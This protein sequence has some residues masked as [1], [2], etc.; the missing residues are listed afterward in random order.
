[1]CILLLGV[2]IAILSD[3]LDEINCEY[4]GSLWHHQD[5]FIS[6]LSKKQ[7][8]NVSHHKFVY[9]ALIGHLLLESEASEYL[10]YL[11]S[12]TMYIELIANDIFCLYQ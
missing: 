10:K 1:M 4:N 12:H 5:N 6:Y 2:K 9:E 3:S 7:A 11:S 8:T